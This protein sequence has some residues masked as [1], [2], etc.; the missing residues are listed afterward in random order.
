MRS[1]FCCLM[2]LCG[3]APPCP[4]SRCCAARYR[5]RDAKARRWYAAKNWFRRRQVSNGRLV[6]Y[7]LAIIAGIF[8][9]AWL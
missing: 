6:I 3:Y 5:E 1:V 9:G 7:V 4:C 8:W 2:D